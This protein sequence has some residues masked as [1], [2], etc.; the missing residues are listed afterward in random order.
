MPLHRQPRVTYVEA[1]PYRSGSCRVGTHHACTEFSPAAAP[2][3]VPVIYEAC[4]CVCH[5]ATNGDSSAEV[6]Q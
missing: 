5:T 6:A 4:D 1:V 2:V 3:D